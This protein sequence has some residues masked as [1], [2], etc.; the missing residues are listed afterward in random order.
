MPVPV[1][2]TLLVLVVL[3]CCAAMAHGW[4]ARTR[5][6]A[7]QVPPPPPPPGPAARGAARSAVFEATYVSSTRAGDWL[8]RVTAHGLGVRTS[9]R[10]QVF[11]AGVLIERTG[12]PDVW[13]PAGALRSVSRSPGQAGKVVGGDGLVVLGWTTG[14]ERGLDTALRLRHRRDAETTL[15]QAT[16]LIARTHEHTTEE[17]R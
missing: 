9:A 6:T 16:A 8:D 7:L 3:A 14:D 4:A 1:A 2:V 17:A 15:A 11:D 5:R 12:A 10:L 13:V